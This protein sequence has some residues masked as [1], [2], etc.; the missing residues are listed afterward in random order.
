MFFVSCASSGGNS[1]QKYIYS[2]LA[3]Y[4]VHSSH[5]QLVDDL[6]LLDED[7]L[8][9]QLFSASQTKQNQVGL[10][11]A[12]RLL[13][14]DP[15]NDE[16]YH[17]MGY[18]LANQKLYT[19]AATMY[20]RA[21]ELNQESH[22]SYYNLGELYILHNKLYEAQHVLEIAHDA[23]PEEHQYS[24][25]LAKVYLMQYRYD[26]ALR[27]YSSVLADLDN[28]QQYRDQKSD[29]FGQEQMY[30]NI[31]YD[32]AIAYFYGKNDVDSAK[33]CLNI[34]ELLIPDDPDARHLRESIG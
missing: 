17:E 14:F 30:Q 32:M 8:W 1:N 23:N 2:I 28:M 31:Y 16:L 33:R 34:Y 19:Q 18:F 24:I 6:E 25:Q 11:L 21:I 15:D 12:T 9:L 3:E 20:R 13:E 7:S 26:D 22:V 4:G 5:A 27:L 10:V 29:K